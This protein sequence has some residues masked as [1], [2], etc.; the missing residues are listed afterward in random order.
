VLKVSIAHSMVQ[1]EYLKQGATMSFGP[2]I[3]A[4]ADPLFADAE[5]GDFHLKS[6]AGR[7][8]PNGYVKDSASSPALGKGMGKAG[9]LGAYGNSAE[10]S[11]AP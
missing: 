11:R 2:G 3:L 10:A 1:T 4:P 7:W 8:T 5:K 6:A 9:E